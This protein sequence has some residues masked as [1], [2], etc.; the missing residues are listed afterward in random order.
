[1]CTPNFITSLATEL[2][3]KN[4][5]WNADHAIAVPISDPVFLRKVFSSSFFFDH[6]F[7]SFFFFPFLV[8]PETQEEKKKGTTWTILTLSRTCFLSISLDK[9]YLLDRHYHTTLQIIQKYHKTPISVC[10]DSLSVASSHDNERR[11]SASAQ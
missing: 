10:T 6:F 11:A 4:I 8:I 3:I 1:M 5:K 7:F 2:K 9:S